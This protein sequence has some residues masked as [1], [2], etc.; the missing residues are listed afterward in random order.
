[1]LTS[2]LIDLVIL[3]T[4]VL[5]GLQLARAIAPAA[6][7]LLLT[8]VAFPLGSGIYTWCVFCLA[9]VGLSIGRG[10]MAFVA[11]ALLAGSLLLGRI[12]RPR[13]GASALPTRV[14]AR[15]S[16]PD[17]LIW[18]ILGALL[19]AALALSVGRSYSAYDAAAGWAVKGYG[20]ALEG[21]LEAGRVWGL[22][23]LGYPLNIMLQIA[24][25]S[26]FEGEVLPGSKLI[27]PL[28]LVAVCL[29]GY[30]FWRKYGVPSRP[31]LL[32][33][34]FLATNP[35]AFLHATNGYANL[36]FA[37]T[38]TIGILLS[39]E[40]LLESSGSLLGI[41]GL[42]LGIAAWTRPEGIGYYLA[43]VLGLVLLRARARIVSR[44]ALAWLAPGAVIVLG[45]YAFAWKAVMVGHLGETIRAVPSG[46][47]LG[48]ANLLEL[49]LIPRL[50]LERAISPGNWGLFLPAVLA[51]SL[52]GL[53]AR[54]SWQRPLMLSLVVLT[55]IAAA[56]PVLIYYA[57]AFAPSTDFQAVLRRDFDRA[58]LPG[59]FMLCITAVQAAA[60]RLQAAIPMVGEPR[61]QTAFPAGARDSRAAR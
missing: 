56:L 17:R 21:E 38:L 23:R 41:G 8:S 26:L 15:A 45:W 47:T 49:Y 14:P 33:T 34:A 4:F 18:G 11:V 57:R 22:F 27:F 61:P 46:L 7:R 30:R 54:R 16:V 52:L 39:V 48:D 58:F 20:M 2:L 25:F 28:Y 59:F 9:W 55:L 43:V 13:A 31:A 60:G 53:A 36:A 44:R 6:D 35:V 24:T 37:A 29:G 42:L 1:M 51:L 5:L 10:L 3:A 40:G 50:F 12:T 19:I 32:A